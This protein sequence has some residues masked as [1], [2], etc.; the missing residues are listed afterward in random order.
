[1]VSEVLTFAVD[2]VVG[3]LAGVDR[4]KMFTAV[5][6]FVT[7]PVPCLHSFN[8]NQLATTHLLKPRIL[9]LLLHCVCSAIA[10]YCN[11]LQYKCTLVKKN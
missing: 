10:Q 1:M 7:L 11:T 3:A 2:V 5:L 8:K 9:T 6:A 4:I